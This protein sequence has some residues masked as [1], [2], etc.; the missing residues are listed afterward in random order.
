MPFQHWRLVP[1]LAVETAL[2]Q[3]S[4]VRR[5]RSKRMR[6]HE[7]GVVSSVGVL[8]SDAGAMLQLRGCHGR[9]R[10]SLQCVRVGLGSRSRAAG[11][12]FRAVH[13][14]GRRTLRPDP[15]RPTCLLASIP[16]RVLALT[17]VHVLASATT[18][19]PHRSLQATLGE[20]ARVLPWALEDAH[21][22]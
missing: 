10:H 1:L 8:T 21:Q 19:Y 9:V 16:L 13:P 6:R 11:L 5:C 3:S 12:G 7:H 4:R 22:P 17:H 15:N 14:W 18:T 20:V 2:L